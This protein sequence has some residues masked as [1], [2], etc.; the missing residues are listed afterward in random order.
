MVSSVCVSVCTSPS[1]STFER[2]A[3]KIKRAR[4]KFELSATASASS[5]SSRAGRSPMSHSAPLMTSSRP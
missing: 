3:R 5:H 4:G 2:D 1:T